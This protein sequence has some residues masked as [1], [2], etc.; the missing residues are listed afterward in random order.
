MTG[1][2][3]RALLERGLHMWNERDFDGYYALFQQ[4]VRYHGSGSV[5]LEGLEALRAH[6]DRALAWC[7][8]LTITSTLALA[9]AERQSC[10]SIQIE[11]GTT[12]SGEPFGFEGMTFYRLGSDGLVAEVWE[13]I[14]PLGA[15]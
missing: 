5:E 6:Y 10:A 15:P 1:D 12:V 4:G 3:M 9:D 8:D 13:K 11:K 7:P 2:E 14:E